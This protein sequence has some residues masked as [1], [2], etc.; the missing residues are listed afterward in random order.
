MA[1]FAGIGKFLRVFDG[2]LGKSL[3]IGDVSVADGVGED[4]AGLE[5]WEML[6]LGRSE[7]KF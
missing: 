1:F 2:V 6:K 3:P 7:V 5:G 4:L